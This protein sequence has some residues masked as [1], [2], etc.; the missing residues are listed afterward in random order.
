M[1]LKIAVLFFVFVWIRATYP[2]FR[3]DH[4]MQIGWKWLI[5]LA[6]LNLIIT[7]VLCLTFPNLVPNAIH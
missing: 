7:A 6:V 4:L 1:I 3:Y 2:R 5:P